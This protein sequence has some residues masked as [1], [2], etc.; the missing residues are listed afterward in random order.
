M[1]AQTAL[2]ATFSQLTDELARHGFETN[3]RFKWDQWPRLEVRCEKWS[4]IFGQGQ[5]P[6]I[7]N[8]TEHE[9][10]P[11]LEILNQDY[12]TDWE[13]IRPHLPAWFDV[14]T[15]EGLL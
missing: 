15:T 13:T 11:T 7:W 8:A 2:E 4:A 10:W 5:V 3:A 9:F 12:A 1:R 6:C 14:L